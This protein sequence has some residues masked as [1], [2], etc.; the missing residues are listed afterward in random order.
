MN[1][2]HLFAYIDA[3]SGS[4]VLQLAVAG[5]FTVL[6]FF[7]RIKQGVAK[8]FRCAPRSGQDED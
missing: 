1:Q 5:I 4:L 8:L 7:R 2:L 6:C 3:G